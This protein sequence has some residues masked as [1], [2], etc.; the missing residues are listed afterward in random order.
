MPKTSVHISV[1]ETLKERV[2]N[3]IKHSSMTY[4]DLA[5][6]AFEDFLKQYDEFVQCDCGAR[7]HIN[8]LVK[9]EGLCPKCDTEVKP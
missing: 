3:K 4:S 1:E 6:S 8:A 9:N 2:E 7:L 5:R